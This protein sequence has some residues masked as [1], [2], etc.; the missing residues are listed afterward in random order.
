M[1]STI[2]KNTVLSLEQSVCIERVKSL[3]NHPDVIEKDIKLLKSYL[4]N[5]NNGL[6]KFMVSYSKKR[7][8]Y[9]TKIC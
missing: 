9:W 3:I 5:Y 2:E 4:K 7:L 8:W 6:K 1:N